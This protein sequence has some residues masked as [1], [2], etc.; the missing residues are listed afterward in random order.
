MGL[1][2][3]ESAAAA[4]QPKTNRPVWHGRLF[5]NFRN[6]LLDAIPHEIRQRGETN[7]LLRRNQFGFNVSGP[8]IIPRLLSAR[9]GT[10]FSLSYEGV[11]EHI[12]RTLLTTVPT[13]AQ[14]AGD[15][16]QTV[17]SGGNP[18]AIF[19]PT[20]TQVNPSFD[21]T[22]AVST[23]NLQYLR[24]Q[25]AGNMIPVSRL[26]PQTISALALYP[27]PNT[28]AG[29][30]FQNNYFVSSPATEHCRRLPR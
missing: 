28:N 30:Y 26:D 23:A 6:D 29:P 12:S 1:R 24:Q 22:Q 16:S 20:S 18:L 27:L 5:E 2:A 25:F 11:R 8:L 3:G 15:F 4:D 19:D 21:P 9:H 13:M 14:R 7:S 10:F 17:D